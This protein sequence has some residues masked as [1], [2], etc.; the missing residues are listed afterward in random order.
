M[1]LLILGGLLLDILEKTCVN[2]SKQ[3]ITIYL[4]VKFLSVGKTKIPIEILIR[5]LTER[6]EKLQVQTFAAY[7]M[8]FV[9]N[10]QAIFAYSA[11][12]VYFILLNYDLCSV[13]IDY[14]RVL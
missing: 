6:A 11:Y 4:H 10:L 7:L 1:I 8:Q 13:R 12:E 5:R 14:L 2:N 9:V 3:F